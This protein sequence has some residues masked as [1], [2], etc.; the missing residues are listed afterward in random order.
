MRRF[1]AALS[2]ALSLVISPALAGPIVGPAAMTFETIS[3]TGTSGVVSLNSQSASITVVNL[4]TTATVYF[5][6]VA[7]ATTSSAPILPQTAYSYFD[8]NAALKS[9]SLITGTGTVSVGV[10]AH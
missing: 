1:L 8:P 4:S 5:S 2:V 10:F 9:F 6:A 7:P 3:A